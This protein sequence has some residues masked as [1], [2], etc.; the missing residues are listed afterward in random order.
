MGCSDCSPMSCKATPLAWVL[1]ELI[2]RA[3]AV[4]GTGV[5][6][7]IKASRH[8]FASGVSRKVYDDGTLA[9]AP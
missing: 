4:S 9:L 3:V 7:L 5:P 6:C 2:V 8:K 1:N